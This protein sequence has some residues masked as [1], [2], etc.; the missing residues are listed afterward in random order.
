[1][2][3][4]TAADLQGNKY[5]TLWKDITSMKPALLLLNLFDRSS[6]CFSPSCLESFC[7]AN[8]GSTKQ[9]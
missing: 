1:M 8:H 5:H 2:S 9:T 3:G 4:I 6:S 7:V